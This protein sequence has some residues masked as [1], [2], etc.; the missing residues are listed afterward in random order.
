MPGARV[1][2][3]D[4]VALRTVEREDLPF[5]QRASANPELRYPM[6]TR[7]RTREEVEESYEDD[8]GETNGR[9]YLVCLESADAPPGSPDEDEVESIG[10]VSVRGLDWRRPELGYWIVPEQQGAGYGS[11]AVS[12]AIDE[13]FRS[14]AAQAVE[15]VAYA[16][17]DAPRG[18]LE[19]LGFE[20]EGVLRKHRFVDGEYV[21]VVMYGLLREDW[22]ESTT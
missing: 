7:L 10:V 6:G 15:A 13:T 19:S 3:A 14:N 21:D 17:N 2:R 16:D 22:I 5:L 18:L 9:R 20:Q 4:D 8:Q 11:T 1:A 12:L